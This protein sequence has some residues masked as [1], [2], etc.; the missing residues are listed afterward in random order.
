[1]GLVDY[2]KAFDSNEKE[3]LMTPL[4]EQEV[5]PIYINDL[6]HIYDHVVSFTCFHKGSKPL[7]LKRGVRQ[8]DTR[9]PKF[10]TACLEQT[11]HQ[12]DK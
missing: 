10:F 12:L 6:C 3:K 11:F 2:T 5:D 4:E 8:S 9:Y 7:Y 1:M